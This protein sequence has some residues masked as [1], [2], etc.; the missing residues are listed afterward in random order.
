VEPIAVSEE[1]WNEYAI[2]ECEEKRKDTP[3]LEMYSASKTLAE[4]G[5]QKSVLRIDFL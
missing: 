2:K 1:T 3:F 4:K 5:E